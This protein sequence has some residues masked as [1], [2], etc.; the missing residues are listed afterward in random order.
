MG[1]DILGRKFA[2]IQDWDHSL[3]YS[4]DIE[5]PD[6]NDEDEKNSSVE[7]LDD[8]SSRKVVGDEGPEESEKNDKETIVEIL[9]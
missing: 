8:D 4:D 6:D 2:S 5:Q 9:I 7:T 1:A 3:L